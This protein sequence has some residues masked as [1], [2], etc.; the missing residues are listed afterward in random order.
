[1]G[2]AITGTFSDAEGTQH[3][4]AGVSVMVSTPANGSYYG[5]AKTAADGSYTV[6]GMPAGTD[7]QHAGSWTL[8]DGWTPF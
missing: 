2:G 5:F 4:L 8:W 3:G 6:Q 7:Y 1:V